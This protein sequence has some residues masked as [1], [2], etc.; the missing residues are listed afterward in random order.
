[1]L[2]GNEP[3]LALED[4]REVMAEEPDS[5]AGFCIKVFRIFHRIIFF[6]INNFFAGKMYVYDCGF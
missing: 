2:I 6:P 1:M 3:R 4:L 5:I